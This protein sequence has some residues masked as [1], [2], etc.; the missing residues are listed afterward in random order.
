MAGCWFV[1]RG[2][3]VRIEQSGFPPIDVDL[4]T[5]GFRAT[6]AGGAGEKFGLCRVDALADHLTTLLVERSAPDARLG[7]AASPSSL[8]LA[9]WWIAREVYGCREKHL[10]RVNPI[11]HETLL[12]LRRANTACAEPG[13]VGER[14]LYRDARV[15][16]DVLRH[17]AAAIALAYLESTFWPELAVRRAREHHEGGSTRAG[18]LRGSAAGLAAVMRNWRALFSPTGASYPALD[19][20]LSALPPD[21]RGDLVCE[22]RNVHLEVAV[23]NGFCLTV[24]LL[25][26]AERDPSAEPEVERSHARV[27]QLA[28]ERELRA[29]VG[30]LLRHPS[31]RTETAWFPSLRR[32]LRLIAQFPEP[33]DGSLARLVQR[34]LD[35]HAVE[36]G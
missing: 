30:A 19:E 20:T 3:G 8:E 22:L 32:A 17:R 14:S 7:E 2:L 16:S 13:L 26:A 21:V 6:P 12:A 9:R 10:S 18:W 35:W 27:L 24:L 1:E 31:L 28:S 15:V 25:R 29:A 5:W 4:E 11:V 34:V 23:R 33:H 36:R